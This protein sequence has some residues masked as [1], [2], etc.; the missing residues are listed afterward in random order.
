LYI[1][2]FA[3]AAHPGL[4]PAALRRESRTPRRLPGEGAL[5]LGALLDVAPPDAPI[6]LE[7]P[8]SRLAGRPAAERARI[9]LDATRA[10]L[11]DYEATRPAR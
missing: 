9:A 5:P 11:A 1:Q 2:A 4:D 10:W 3:A 6:S 8:S 7:A